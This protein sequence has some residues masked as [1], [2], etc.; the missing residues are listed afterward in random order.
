[1]AITTRHFEEFLSLTPPIPPTIN[2]GGYDQ[3]N[4]QLPRYAIDLRTWLNSV[5][6]N[7][8]GKDKIFGAAGE[9]K[10]YDYPNPRGYTYPS[11]LRVFV[12]PATLTVYPAKLHDWPVPKGYIFPSDLR[13]WL[14]SVNLNLIGKDNN[15]KYTNYDWPV[16][17][18]PIYSMDLRTYV[19]ALGGPMFELRFGT[20][21][22]TLF[23]EGS[24]AVGIFN[25]KQDK[26]LNVTIK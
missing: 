3:P 10:S 1:V 15:I 16:P 18:A 8:L 20:V 7:L 12:G 5:N 17:K 19:W 2:I 11:D 23:F 4:P 24:D 25:T 26:L 21:Q 22:F 6:L 13:T 9:T 14:N